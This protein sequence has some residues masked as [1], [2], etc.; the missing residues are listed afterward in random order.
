MIR[1]FDRS[2]PCCLTESGL[3]DFTIFNDNKTYSKST[4]PEG[5][6]VNVTATARMGSV[7]NI[8]VARK[9]KGEMLESIKQSL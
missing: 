9:L 2:N 3:P 8:D 1:L 7:R 5:G 6:P 4:P